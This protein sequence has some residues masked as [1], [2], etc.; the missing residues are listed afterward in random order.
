MAKHWMGS[1][2]H[3]HPEG[4]CL[5]AVGLERV[6]YSQGPGLEVERM[7]GLQEICRSGYFPPVIPGCFSNQFF[8]PRSIWYCQFLSLNE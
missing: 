5:D 3:P 7:N 2:R 4:I 6:V 8:E 1:A